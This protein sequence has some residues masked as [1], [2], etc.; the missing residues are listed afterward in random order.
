[1]QLKTKDPLDALRQ[2][3]VAP[4]PTEVKAEIKFSIYT[5]KSDAGRNSTPPMR[6]NPSNSII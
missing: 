1:M 2:A 6:H 5:L 4:E 3:K